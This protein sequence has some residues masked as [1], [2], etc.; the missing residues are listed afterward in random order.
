MCTL[1]SSWNELLDMIAPVCHTPLE[2]TS[3]ETEKLFWLLKVVSRGMFCSE[4][5]RFFLGWTSLRSSSSQS[6]ATYC[7]SGTKADLLLADTAGVLVK[8]GSDRL[9]VRRR[10]LA[11]PRFCMAFWYSSLPESDCGGNAVSLTAYTEGRSWLGGN[12]CEDWAAGE[13]GLDRTGRR[14]LNEQSES[15]SSEELLLF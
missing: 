8:A 11:L 7:S 4:T 12:S 10:D 14:G 9:W 15:E 3:A 5:L 2:E 1:Q 13:R 6:S